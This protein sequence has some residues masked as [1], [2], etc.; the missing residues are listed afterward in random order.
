M[1]RKS[2]AEATSRTRTRSCRP[3]RAT[4][5][6]V[7]ARS[8]L[9]C[10]DR[11]NDRNS[12]AHRDFFASQPPK[13]NGVKWHPGARERFPVLRTQVVPTCATQAGRFSEGSPR[14]PRSHGR[15]AGGTPTRPTMP[16]RHP[17]TPPAPAVADRATPPHPRRPTMPP[18]HWVL[19]AANIKQCHDNSGIDTAFAKAAPARPAIQYQSGSSLRS[20]SASALSLRPSGRILPEFRR[21]GGRSSG[22][23]GGNATHSRKATSSFIASDR[24]ILKMFLRKRVASSLSK[25]RTRIT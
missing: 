7:R 9:L 23:I 15:H 5:G 6:R 25:P 14:T 24:A 19:G 2:D 1:T 11:K 21:C 17:V 22:S 13:V 4:A 20:F 3:G 16:P 18:R 10:D 12:H 8:L